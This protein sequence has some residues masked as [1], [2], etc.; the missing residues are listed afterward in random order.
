MKLELP[1]Q[2]IVVFLYNG[3]GQLF[4]ADLGVLAETE[5]RQ[6]YVPVAVD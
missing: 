1:L 4:R 2:Y 6:L 3:F 5:V